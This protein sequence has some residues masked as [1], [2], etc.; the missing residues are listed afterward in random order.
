MVCAQVGFFQARENPFKLAKNSQRQLPGCWRPQSL[1]SLKKAR[2]CGSPPGP[3]SAWA[4][5][6]SRWES[7]L[8]D[9]SS[10]VPASW[11]GRKRFQRAA[12]S[13][14]LAKSHL[15]CPIIYNLT[16][17][18]REAPGLGDHGTEQNLLAWVG[19]VVNHWSF[20]SLQPRGTPCRP[21]PQPWRHVLRPSARLGSCHVSQAAPLDPRT[22]G[23]FPNLSVYQFL[24]D[25]RAVHAIP[26]LRLFLKQTMV[27]VAE[28]PRGRHGW[29]ALC[30]DFREPLPP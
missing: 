27:Q 7:G 26:L 3:L 12:G 25:T 18:G 1:Y 21:V 9:Q 13:D 30:C 10:P 8:D 22:Q 23:E 11:K 14:L 17:H 24:S 20:S 19:R 29:A 2:A 16:A 4:P 28:T 6:M 5:G 15:P